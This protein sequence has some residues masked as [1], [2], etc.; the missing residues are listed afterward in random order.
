MVVGQVKWFNAKA[1]FGFV[2]V[3]EGENKGKD[4]FA[5][6]SGIKTSKEQ[7]RYLVEG[8][9]VEMEVSG[10]ENGEHRHQSKGVTGVLE[11]KLMCE[12][13]EEERKERKSVMEQ[14]KHKPKMEVKGKSVKDGS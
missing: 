14:L 11:G 5:H 3:M 12:V 6:H 9:Y 10:T 13:R 1:G 7:F 2:T 8:E 4:I